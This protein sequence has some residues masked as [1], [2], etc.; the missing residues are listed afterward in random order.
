MA[1]HFRPFGD[2]EFIKDCIG[3]FVDQ[4][5]PKKGLHLKIQVF[6]AP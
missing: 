1:K 5:C 6:L 3:M 2:G 4:M